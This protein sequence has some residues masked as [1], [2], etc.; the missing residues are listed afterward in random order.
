MAVYSNDGTEFS[1]VDQAGEVFNSMPGY[2]DDQ[3]IFTLAPQPT[4]DPATFKTT[5][6]LVNGKKVGAYNEY[7]KAEKSAIILGLEK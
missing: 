5:W 1:A 7:P 6:L 2:K 4:G 3:L